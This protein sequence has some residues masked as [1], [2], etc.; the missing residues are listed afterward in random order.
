M[1]LRANGNETPGP[2]QLV[3]HLWTELKK[4][5]LKCNFGKFGTEMQFIKDWTVLKELKGKDCLK[6]ELRLFAIKCKIWTE[7]QFLKVLGLK[8]NNNKIG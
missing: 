3:W 8:C 4:R 5:G 2:G 7:L 1:C 6:L